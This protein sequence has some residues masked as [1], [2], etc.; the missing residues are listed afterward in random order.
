[1]KD[2]K[3]PS[4]LPF[5]DFDYEP[6][7]SMRYRSEINA[8]TLLLE[9]KEE[10]LEANP[11]NEHAYVNGALVDDSSPYSVKIRTGK[12]DSKHEAFKILILALCAGLRR[13]EIDLLQ[14]SQIMWDDCS[15]RIENTDCFT[16]KADS[17]GDVPVDPEIIELFRSFYENSNSRFVIDGTE[18]NP[19]AKYRYYRTHR[20]H[21]TL[22]DWLRSKGVTAVNPIHSLRKEFGSILCREAGIL[23]ASR[24]LRHASIMITEKHYIENQRRVTA[25]LGSLLRSR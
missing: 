4:P 2:I 21:R 10:L 6:Q 13:G 14:W 23:V 5:S 20:H 17:C 19:A 24:L 15:I 18:P 3:L 9:A 16:P 12:A 8:E 25:G 7:G 22:L 11:E 1:M